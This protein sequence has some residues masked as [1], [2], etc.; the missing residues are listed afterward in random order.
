MSLE[1]LDTMALH[2]FL[3]KHFKHPPTAMIVYDNDGFNPDFL[4]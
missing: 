1:T 2:F 4:H 3:L